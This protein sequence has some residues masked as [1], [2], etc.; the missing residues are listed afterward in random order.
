MVI[1]V[2]GAIS[3]AAFTPR[4]KSDEIESVRAQVISNI[5]RMPVGV[6]LTYTFPDGQ[7]VTKVITEEFKTSNIQ[8]AK[9][10]NSFFAGCGATNCWCGFECDGGYRWCYCE[11]EEG[12]IY[13][14]PYGSC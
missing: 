6:T 10:A 7:V 3:L 8:A 11:T 9:N 12:M 1:V 5:E 14:F 13:W 4:N 2:L